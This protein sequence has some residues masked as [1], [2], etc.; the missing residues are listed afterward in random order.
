MIWLKI[1]NIPTM[2]SIWVKTEAATQKYSCQEIPDFSHVW[3]QLHAVLQSAKL[4]R[5][6]HISENKEINSK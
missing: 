2:N 3:I 4:P 1:K 6:P 5:R